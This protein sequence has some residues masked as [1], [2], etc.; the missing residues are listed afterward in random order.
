MHVVSGAFESAD[1]ALEW[2]EAD[3]S[4]DEDEPTCGFWDDI[5]CAD[6]DPDGQEV[7]HARRVGQN[8]EFCGSPE[9]VDYDE[10]KAPLRPQSLLPFKLDEV[11]VRES[12]RRPGAAASPRP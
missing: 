10:I 9:L 6:I 1:E 5:G 7:I 4:L 8:C 2:S 12:V 11:R 3:Y